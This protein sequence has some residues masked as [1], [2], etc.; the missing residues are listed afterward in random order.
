M[1][2]EMMTS[3]YGFSGQSSVVST[4]KE[5]FKSLGFCLGTWCLMK[6][7]RMI[8]IVIRV[9]LTVGICRC[10]TLGWISPTIICILN[11]D[12]LTMWGCLVDAVC[13]CMIQ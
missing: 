10:K 9:P 11:L 13:F 7:Q 4:I 5:V 2:Q 8:G 6:L 1:A 3:V 12:A